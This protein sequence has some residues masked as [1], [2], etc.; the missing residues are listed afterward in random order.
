[1]TGTLIEVDG[2][3]KEYATEDGTIT[4]V[5]GV[6]VEIGRGEIVGI[7]GPNGAGKTTMIKSVL[8]LVAPTE[9]RIDVGGIDPTQN[10]RGAYRKISAVLEGARNIYWRLTPDEN[11]RFFAGLQGRPAAETSRLSDELLSKLK[12]EGKAD[13]PVRDL[14]RGMKQRVSIA[15]ALARDTPGIFLDEPTLGLD[16]E[17]SRKLQR[18]LRRLVDSENRT[19]VLSSHD[20]DVVSE[21]CDRVVIMNE[22]GI[23]TDDDVDA[24]IDVFDVQGY[25]LEVSP[26]PSRET[27]SEFDVDW[28]R[29]SD[30]TAAFEVV[31]ED[32]DEIYAMMS[33][34]EAAGLTVET[35]ESR[36]PDLEEIFVEITNRR[37]PRE[38]PA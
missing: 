4:A 15:C 21:V 10:P 13:E 17:S 11:V 23:I 32:D 1:M 6:S 27:L 36:T 8:G 38:V 3:T 18:E 25:R 33:A 2:L 16:V 28:Q 26:V 29:R 31:M 12:L 19:I 34:L 37:G 9:G 14:S 20:M 24:L 30:G 7:L 22:G 5:D 35:I